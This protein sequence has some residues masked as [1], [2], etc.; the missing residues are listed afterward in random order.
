MPIL[1]TF[2]IWAILVGQIGM[3][4]ATVS[5]TSL[6]IIVD[7]TVHFLTKYLRARREQGLDRP[8]A[9]NYAF[10]TVGF[11]IFATSII[12]AAGFGVLAFSTFKITGEMGTLTALAIIIAL[13]GDFL[14]LPSLLLLGSKKTSS[15]GVKP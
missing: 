2:G 15:K 13:V 9:I 10:R 11:A 6:G 1:M 5:A 7:D 14:F 12:L 4:A 3:A 8:G